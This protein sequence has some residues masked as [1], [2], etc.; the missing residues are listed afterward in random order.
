MDMSAL[1]QTPDANANNTAEADANQ[2]PARLVLSEAMPLLALPAHTNAIPNSIPV[3]TPSPFESAKPPAAPDPV[4]HV[5]SS[6]KIGS[7]AGP[8]FSGKPTRSR[9]PKG[10]NRQGRGLVRVLAE[11]L[12]IIAVALSVALLVRA[13]VV[14]AFW[15]PTTSMTPTLKVNDRLLVDKVSFQVREIQRGEIIVFERPAKLQEDFKDLIKRVVGLPGDTVE[16]RDGAVFVNGKKLAEPYLPSG[17][18]TNDFPPQQV[19]IDNYFV[20]GDNRENSWDSRY[21]GTV[22]RKLVVGKAI[23]R[24]W[25]PSQVGRL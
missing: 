4:P 16:G 18:A 6:P 25:P 14:Q 13:T 17:L 24:V 1:T 9:G 19:P 2:E 23:V 7:G 11:W 22:E 5:A 3:P 12:T 21:W 15:I 20:M 8:S 10:R